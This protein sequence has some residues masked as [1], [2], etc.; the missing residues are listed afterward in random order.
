MDLITIQSYTDRCINNRK[1]Q[2]QNIRN[3]ISLICIVQNKSLQKAIRE[4][5]IHI[6]H[7]AK[8]VQDAKTIFKSGRVEDKNKEG[9][10]SVA[11]AV[12]DLPLTVYAP[13]LWVYA[14]KR[15]V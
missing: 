14:S 10:H 15:V 7:D 11:V 5:A 1:D 13:Y 8:Q 12:I 3:T 2:R 4:H 9:I 6:A